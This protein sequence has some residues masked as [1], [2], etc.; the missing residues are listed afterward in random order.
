LDA[1]VP[2]F[3]V[4]RADVVLLDDDRMN[5]GTDQDHVHS[6]ILEEV[7]RRDASE[8]PW[9]LFLVVAMMGERILVSAMVL[10]AS[11]GCYSDGFDFF[12]MWNFSKMRSSPKK[13]T[14]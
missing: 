1:L 14:F 11:V 13:R 7:L 9:V 10:D 5:C 12:L 6:H 2:H 3:L 8:D 4:D